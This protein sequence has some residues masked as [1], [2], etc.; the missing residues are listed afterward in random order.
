MGSLS[1]N[2]F[3]PL[4]SNTLKNESKMVVD[5][6]SDYYNNIEKYP[7]RS[8]VQPGYLS[9]KL[10]Q[11]A[12]CCPES[13][14]DIL[15]DVSDSI[16]P[17][18]T[19][20]QSPNF[21]AYFQANASNAGFVGE[22]LC[23]GLNI[24]GFSWI[25]SPA[26]TEL[27]SLV[28]DW[29]GKLL[30]LPSSFLFSGNGGGVLHG[31]TCE[32]IVCTLAAARDKVLKRMGWDKI[33]KLV[34]YAS[35][36]THATLHKGTK[37]V[38]IPSSNIR[39]LSTSFSSGFSLSP[40]TLQEAIENDIKSGF[41]PLF[42]CAT[43]GTTACGAVDPIKE[44]GEIAKKYNIWLHIDAAYAGS[45]CICPE[46]RHYLNGVELA[47]SV[48]MNPHKWLLT[49]MDCCCLWVKQPYSLIDSLTSDAEYLRNAA[50]E[51]NNVVDYKDW[52]IALSKR[53]RALKLWVVIRRHGLSNLMYHI[54]SD[55]KL[56]KWFE[57][58]VGNDKR[59][60]IVVPR[61]F[62]LVCFRLKPKNG[63]DGSKLNRQLLFAVNESGRAFMTHGVAGGVYFLR[64]AIGS[65]LTEERHVSELWKLIQE[66]AQ[67][68]LA[69]ATT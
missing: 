43:V 16:L 57:S 7:V 42:L 8:E 59:F 28:M 19:H 33:T 53:F 68:I 9:A 34:V 5:F 41:I 60:E 69:N 18:L 10:P 4:D 31:S 24:V 39:S 40:Q 48:S 29:M 15:K 58:L 17:G 36:Q 38:G 62:A 46:F 45:A 66:K 35:D 47:D 12:P 50:T 25:S 30:N 21:F 44:L 64:C 56:A 2:T 27:E 23:S 49:N 65:T 3:S 11:S 63:I 32:A 37:L 51:S 6:I 1:A 13:L 54:R 67:T 20:W 22:M 14:E 55:V 26:A 61:R 52:Q